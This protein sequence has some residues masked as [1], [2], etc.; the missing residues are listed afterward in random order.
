MAQGLAFGTGNAVAHEAVRSAMHSNI[1]VQIVP[2][3]EQ[4]T[5]SDPCKAILE[6]L[7]ECLEKEYNCDHILDK[8]AGCSTRTPS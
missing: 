8:L 5:N 4:V 2:C 1:P 6:E 7:H 3:K